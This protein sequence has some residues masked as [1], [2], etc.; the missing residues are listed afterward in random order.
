M[1]TNKLK[2]AVVTF[3]VP[4]LILFV[5]S[6]IFGLNSGKN[7]YSV[8][9]FSFLF[10]LPF[11]AGALTVYLSKVEKVESLTFRICAPWVTII[12]FFFLTL[13]LS[14]E[15]WACWMMIL[16]IFMFI[17]SIGGVYGGYLKMKR[18]K[19]FGQLNI[20]LL[21]LLPFIAAPIESLMKIIPGK[22][23]AYTFID[24]SR[25]T[26][27]KIWSN[28]T[29]VKEIKQEQDKGWL[30]KF[31]DFPRPIKAELNYEGVGAA[32]E[33]IFSGGLTFHE[34]VIYYEDKKKMR[35]SIKAFPYEIP[36]TTMDKHVV[37]GGD[38]FDVLDGTYEL[39]KI[40]D[41]TYRLHLYSHFKL[42]TTFNFY[43]SYWAGWIMKDI[44][45]NILQ[46]IKHRSEDE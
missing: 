45:N 27:D 22:Y 35:F 24:I 1:N 9:S 10:F 16:P 2:D 5:I 33:A 26:P 36:S 3:G 14:F 44:Q 46:V 29:R 8:M 38:Y 13:I 28:V 30:T 6:S 11:I 42:T 4:I 20:S 43:A 41:R 34:K 15:G 17:S 19:R 18:A 39:Q 7:L 25:S 21:I 40:N 37:I 32:R 12:T 31:L 23:E